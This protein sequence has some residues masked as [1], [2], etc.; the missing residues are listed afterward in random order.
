MLDKNCGVTQ[1]MKVLGNKWSL[2]IIHNLCSN[3][4]RFNELSRKIEKISPK[5][6]STQL[7]ILVENGIAIKTIFDTNP[8]QV[9]YSLTTKGQKL[10]PILQDLEN[11]GKKEQ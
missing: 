3:P 6:L 7:K 5:M 8:P 9:Q 11:W 10:K 1:A 2:I 4:L